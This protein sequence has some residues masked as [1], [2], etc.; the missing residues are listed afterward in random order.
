[1]AAMYS[2]PKDLMTS[3]MKSAPGWSSVKTSTSVETGSVS[4][5]NALADGK[6]AAPRDGDCACCASAS[7]AFVARVAAPIAAPFKKPRRLKRF[8]L[9]FSMDNLLY[10]R[11]IRRNFPVVKQVAKLRYE[12]LPSQTIHKAKRV[13]LDTLGCALGAVDPQRNSVFTS[14]RF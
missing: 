8:L 11:T 12:D 14:R 1:M 5:A 6:G 13:L 7:W 9:D 10:R 4:A 3:T 2:I